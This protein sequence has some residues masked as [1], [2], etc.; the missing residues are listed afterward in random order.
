[1]LSYR[2]GEPGTSALVDAL[3]LDP[4]AEVVQ[5]GTLGQAAIAAMLATELDDDVDPAFTVACRQAPAAI[6]CSSPS[7][8]GH[9]ERNASVHARMRSRRC[10]HSAGL[11]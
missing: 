9:F 3:G 4:L 6:R 1:M 11:R 10:G 7:C 2:T 8:C 5:P